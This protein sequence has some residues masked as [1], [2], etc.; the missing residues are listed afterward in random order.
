MS[1]D[2]RLTRG[3]AFGLGLLTGTAATVAVLANRLRVYHHGAYPE[4]GTALV[5]SYEP[6]DAE[7]QIRREHEVEHPS[8]SRV[9]EL[10][11][12]ARQHPQRPSRTVVIIG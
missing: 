5:V 12:R 10:V 3:L 2:T 11:Q 7:P 4:C 9:G 8:G 1:D 6:A